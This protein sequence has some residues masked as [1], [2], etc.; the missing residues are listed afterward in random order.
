MNRWGDDWVKSL[1]NMWRI[2][3]V[4]SELEKECM[5][6]QCRS[7]KVFAFLCREYIS[8]QFHSVGHGFK[9]MKQ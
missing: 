6:T 2:E 4:W 7:S 8:K 1:D 9:G 5:Y 3:T